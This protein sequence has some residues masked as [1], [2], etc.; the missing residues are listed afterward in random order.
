MKIWMRLTLLLAALLAGTAY[1]VWGEAPATLDSGSTESQARREP[2]TSK[3]LVADPGPCGC[4]VGFECI[5][6]PRVGFITPVE[7]DTFRAG[8][9]ANIEVFACDLFALGLGTEDSTNLSV[10]CP[11]VSLTT[12]EKL[13]Q[14]TPSGAGTCE[15]LVTAGAQQFRGKSLGLEAKL[16]VPVV[17]TAPSV[18]FT[19]PTPDLAIVEGNLV[20]LSATA[21]DSDGSVVSVTFQVRNRSTQAQIFTQVDSSAPYGAN[22]P[23]TAP[24]NYVAT[25]RALDNEGNETQTSV[26]FSVNARPTITF[27]Q[28]VASSFTAPANVVFEV[29]AADSDGSIKRVDFELINT[30]SGQAT[31]SSDSL[32]PYTHP[33]NGLAAA[34]YRMRAWAFDNQDGWREATRDITV[35]TN[36]PPVVALTS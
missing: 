33:A 12:S 30:V 26:H 1:A 13:V 6:T 35:S 14:V 25:A 27:V 8:E 23:W 36:P 34:S 19:W 31:R 18:A 11:G 20:Q 29:S 28:P 21:T 10:T 2:V 16:S 4:P 22:L 15:L 17:S 7:G 24:G 5:P 3:E 32:P 9:T